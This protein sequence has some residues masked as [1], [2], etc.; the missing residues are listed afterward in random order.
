MNEKSVSIKQYGGGK[1][2]LCSLHGQYCVF[3]F[4]SFNWL[5]PG[6]DCAIGSKQHQAS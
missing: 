4:L 6:G 5:K 3:F 1:A 2:E